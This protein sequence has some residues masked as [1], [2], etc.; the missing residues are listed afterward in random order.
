MTPRSALAVAALLGGL[1]VGLGAFGAHGLADRVSPADLATF[2]TGTRYQVYHALA[3]LGLAAWLDRQPRRRLEAAAWAFTIGVTIFS[4]SL[5]LLVLTGARWL[6]A[7]TP[8]GGVLLIGG[9]LLVLV[10]A[11]ARDRSARP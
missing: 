1:G 5:Y 10:E 9:W 6:G 8:L 3:L 2:D 4:G 7:I 11:T